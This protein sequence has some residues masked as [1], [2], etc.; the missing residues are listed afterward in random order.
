MLKKERYEE[1]EMRMIVVAK[2]DIVTGSNE[3]PIQP[4]PQSDR[5][6]LGI[7]E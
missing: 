1:P 7:D 5:E 6:L 2:E 4:M 3:L